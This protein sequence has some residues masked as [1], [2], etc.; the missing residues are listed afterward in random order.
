[1]LRHSPPVALSDS[2]HISPV[3]GCGYLIRAATL[4]DRDALADVYL[5]C[6]RQTF[7]WVDP[8]QYQRADFIEDTEGE[9][10]L[11]CECGG[12]IVGFSGVWRQD[13]FLHHLFVLPEHQG[14]GAGLALLRAAMRDMDGPARLKCVAQNARALRFY[15]GLGGVIES[16]SEDG[17]E[18]P[19]HTIR[20]PNPLPLGEV[21]A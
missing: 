18:G 2:A 12:Q 15:T 6:R 1:M 13:N 14:H 7:S 10:V 21:T 20:L 19:Y 8:V 5:T 4:T 17:P 16:T 3:S 11:V 9:R